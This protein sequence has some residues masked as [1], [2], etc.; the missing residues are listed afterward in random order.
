[1]NTKKQLKLNYFLIGFLSVCSINS[2]AAEE[3]SRTQLFS[4]KESLMNLSNDYSSGNY[5]K[6]I[7][8]SKKLLQL[9]SKNDDFRNLYVL[10]SYKL[11]NYKAIIDLH[12]ENEIEYLTSPVQLKLRAISL[13]K[14]ASY[15]QS[16]IA[17]KTLREVEPLTSEWKYFYHYLVFKL[18]S[19]SAFKELKR[20]NR[21]SPNVV[22]DI[23]TGNL[24]LLNE[25]YNEAIVSFNAALVKDPLNKEVM[26][27]LGDSYLKLRDRD[28]ALGIYSSLLIISP[29]SSHVKIKISK[30]LV[31][32]GQYLNALK[33]LA[34]DD[35][36]NVVEFRNKLE[37]FTSQFLNNKQSRAIAEEKTAINSLTPGD[38]RLVLEESFIPKEIDIYAE[39]IIKFS[40][41]GKP[42]PTE[43]AVVS[44]VV[45]PKIDRIH[46]GDV[47]TVELSL[48]PKLK[49]YDLSGVGFNAKVDYSSG[50]V[51]NGKFN[52]APENRNWDSHVEVEH[53]R[54]E[55]K[56]LNGVTPNKTTLSETKASVG[57]NYLL[58]NTSIGPLLIY[59]TM[60]ANQTIPST[61]R[62]NVD[63]FNLGARVGHTFQVTDEIKIKLEAKYFTKVVT[64][65]KT[66][67]V[68]NV[69]KH[70]SVGAGGIFYYETRPQAHI[71]A[72]VGYSDTTTKYKGSSARGTVDAKETEKDILFPLGISYAF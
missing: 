65:S 59:E 43:V 10:A 18:N 35:S 6:V 9:D 48:G 27:I 26:E 62:G 60:S 64:A 28:K 22:N 16:M 33:K 55:L 40:E 69:N 44:N 56:S 39:P 11:K 17:L 37:N 45:G 20:M 24:Y 52:F 1:M 49:S 2:R 19:K 54:V 21:V 53:S 13:A 46:L 4:D 38:G 29:K 7:E 71:F 31:K 36:S 3:V 32:K 67:A 25:M 23:T 42:V 30:V 15:Y 12:K 50:L 61:L 5:L 66:I 70:S 14:E 34:G 47:S 63:F 58:G 72:G 57:V 41:K 68:G 8:V 51:V